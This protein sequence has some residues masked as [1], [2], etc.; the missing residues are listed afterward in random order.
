MKECQRK[1]AN[2]RGYEVRGSSAHTDLDHM[3]TRAI[4]GDEAHNLAIWITRTH[5]EPFL[6]LLDPRSRSHVHT[7]DLAQ[8]VWI[9]GT[10]VG[11]Y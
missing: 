2:Q 11:T 9:P 4:F 7:G 6:P 3:Y 8:I 10:S 5:Q 1:I